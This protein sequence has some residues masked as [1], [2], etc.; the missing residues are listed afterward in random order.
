[1][2][3]VITCE[4]FRN[5]AEYFYLDKLDLVQRARYIQHRNNCTE[6][7]KWSRESFMSRW[8]A[9]GPYW[10]LAVAPTTSEEYFRRW[11][12]GTDTIRQYNA[13]ELTEEEVKLVNQHLY[14][15]DCDSCLD[16]IHRDKLRIAYEEREK[17]WPNLIVL[18]VEETS[19]QKGRQRINLDF[20]WDQQSFK[21]AA[22][23]LRSTSVSPVRETWNLL[24]TYGKDGISLT[25]DF[26]VRYSRLLVELVQQTGTEPRPIVLFFRGKEYTIQR[27]NSLILVEERKLGF[28]WIPSWETVNIMKASV[29][30]GIQDR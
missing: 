8:K 28:E 7:R 9:D 17:R 22:S 27:G 21:K 12:L 13:G 29:K 1:M 2:F 25:L 10:L 30:V 16:L 23:G 14:D 24:M 15:E 6:C 19:I 20:S 26:V 11:C 3:T 5:Q 4:D 18:D